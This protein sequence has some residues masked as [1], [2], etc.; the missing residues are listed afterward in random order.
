VDDVV[1]GVITVVVVVVVDAGG[2][3]E[4]WARTPKARRKAM[5]NR[6]EVF[7]ASFLGLTYMMS[8]VF[9]CLLNRVAPFMPRP[10]L[11]PLFSIT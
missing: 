8:L 10:G 2:G 3:V 5:Q 11:Q 6:A 7:R 9:R 4:D 1:V